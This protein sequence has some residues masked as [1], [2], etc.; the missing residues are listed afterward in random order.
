MDCRMARIVTNE[1]KHN[2]MEEMSTDWTSACEREA[3]TV[4]LDNDTENSLTRISHDQA[5]GAQRALQG[6][7]HVQR[8]SRKWTKHLNEQKVRQK[9]RA[10]ELMEQIES[11]NWTS[12]R[13][14]TFAIPT[15]LLFLSNILTASSVASPLKVKNPRASRGTGALQSRFKCVG[16][17]YTR[18]PLRS[19]VWR[20]SDALDWPESSIV[21]NDPV[22][23]EHPP[24]N[25]LSGFL[26]S[27]GDHSSGLPNGTMGKS[28]RA[29][30]GIVGDEVDTDEPWVPLDNH[31]RTRSNVR[32]RAYW[33][34]ASSSHRI[35]RSCIHSSSTALFG[36]RE[37]VFAVHQP[38]GGSP[39]A[40]PSP[41]TCIPS[42]K[43]T[44]AGH[45]Q[46]HRDLALHAATRVRPR[47]P[48]KLML[49]E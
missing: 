35:T 14:N 8:I 12:P 19:T 36:T 7:A 17:G 2:F 27:L 13:R 23:H 38:K 29:Q 16:K 11:S 24:R 40:V 41:P 6:Y 37:D 5:P 25:L 26:L 9:K 22:V 42:L 33:T 48:R 15:R 44:G 1:V 20:S 28:S 45:G 43:R 49:E 18:I 39:S 4:P 34:A 31:K 30:A 47:K 32:A 3:Q 10:Y 21:L 46:E